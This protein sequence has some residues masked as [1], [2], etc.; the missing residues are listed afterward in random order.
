MFPQVGS[1][2]LSKSGFIEDFCDGKFIEAHPLFSVHTKAL[3]VV[4]YYDEVEVCNHLGSKA[5]VHKLG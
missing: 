4:F 5:K 2:N 3:Q 1:G